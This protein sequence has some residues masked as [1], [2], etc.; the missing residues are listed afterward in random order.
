M[1]LHGFSVKPAMRLALPCMRESMFDPEA[2]LAKPKE[3][4]SDDGWMRKERTN[5]NAAAANGCNHLRE[6]C[7]AG[8]KGDHARL[9]E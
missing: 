3:S 6:K 4:N 1:K 7:G 8:G 5:T 9:A 2:K